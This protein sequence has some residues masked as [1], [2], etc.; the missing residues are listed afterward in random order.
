[1]TELTGKW[2]LVTGSSRGIGQQIALGLSKHGVNVVLHGRTKGSTDATRSMLKFI[3]VQ[4]K[5]V[6]GEMNSEVG[7]KE[8]VARTYEACEKID[9]LYGNHGIQNQWKNVWE[10]E[11]AE[12]EETFQINFFSMVTL[13]NGFIPRM[14]KNGFG[15]VVLTTSGI[16]DIPQLTPYGTSKAAIDKYVFDLSAQLKESGVKINSMDPGWLRTDLGGPNGMFPVEAVLPGAL[17][18]VITDVLDSGTVFSAQNYR[19]LDLSKR[20]LP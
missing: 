3:G 14:V 2:A 15:R 18:P 11:Q 12:W 20:Q 17:V 5:T 19:G 1:M 9:I 16:P 8:V 7:A 4:V 6:Y 13:C 10:I